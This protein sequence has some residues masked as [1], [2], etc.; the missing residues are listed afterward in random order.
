[1]AAAESRQDRMSCSWL[2]YSMFRFKSLRE[3][4]CVFAA[5]CVLTSPSAADEQDFMEEFLKREYSLAKPYRGQLTYVTLR[6]TAVTGD[7]NGRQRVY[8]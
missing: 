5:V 4:T 1:M 7:T 2:F 8:G 6:Q 3:L